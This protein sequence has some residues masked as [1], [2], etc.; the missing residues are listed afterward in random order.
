[1]FD[2]KRLILKPLSERVH[3]D[4]LTEIS[5]LLE[6]NITYKNN[7][8]N[9]VCDRIRLARNNNKPVILM[10]GAHV[11]RKGL[12]PLIIKLMEKGWLTH[13]A[14]NG[15]GAIHDFELALIGK[16]AE[17]V[18][19]YIKEGQFGLWNET[20]RV[21]DAVNHG[22][23]KGLG[24]GESVGKYIVENVE[25]VENADG[26]DIVENTER[27]ENKE[28]NFP[29]YKYSVFASAYKLKIPITV[30]VG[31]GYDIVHEHPNCN[32]AAIGATSYK[33]F[34]TFASTLEKL[35]GG[36]YL[37]YGSAVMGPEVFLKALSMV[38]NVAH[39]NNRVINKFTTAVFDLADIGNDFSSEVA[40]SNHHYYFR[41]FKTLLVR[42]VKDGGE[43]FYIRGDHK[44]T[45]AA[46]YRNLI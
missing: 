44:A 23:E 9:Q 45:L 16:T 40:K 5:E 28:N 26:K 42:T 8:L 29:Y 11:I 15:A 7:D 19:K 3:D 13:I 32:G 20:G 36:V 2:R 33:D 39:Q 41:P 35:E 46:L 43:S 24:F 21:N 6:N 1:M 18:A 30:H 4:K 34:L 38:R 25:K 31:I 14:T 17:S 10:M 12:S 37:S 27:I 22:Y